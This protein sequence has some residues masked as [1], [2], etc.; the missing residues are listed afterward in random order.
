ME[1][2]ALYKLNKD[3]LIMLIEEIQEKL[4]K[5]VEIKD[6]IL[7]AAEVEYSRCAHS[8]CEAFSVY[9]KWNNFVLLKC[10]KCVLCFCSKHNFDRIF[11]GRCLTCQY[12]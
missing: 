2:S 4:K 9:G 12:A 10:E 6:N 1:K 5:E 7:N 11:A 3:T 8:D